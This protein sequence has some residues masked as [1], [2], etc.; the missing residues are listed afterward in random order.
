MFGFIGAA[1]KGVAK[2]LGGGPLV[3][4]MLDNTAERI[5]A[6]GFAIFCL[7]FGIALVRCSG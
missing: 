2:L 6:S 4:D 3:P 1:V 5:A 7:L